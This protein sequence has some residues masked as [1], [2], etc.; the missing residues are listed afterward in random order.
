MLDSSPLPL[1]L[2]LAAKPVA[3][4]SYQLPLDDHCYILAANGVFRLDRNEYYEIVTKLT[5]LPNLGT[6]EPKRRLTVLKIPSHFVRDAEAFFTAVYDRQ[7]SE[8]VLLLYC[9]PKYGWHMEAPKQEAQGLHVDYDRTD[10]P[11]TFP[12]YRYFHPQTNREL[13]SSTRP[14][15]GWAIAEAFQYRLFGTI[16]SHAQAGA[17][18][19]G[20]DDADEKHFDGLHITIGNVDAAYSYSAR[21]SLGG[22]FSKVDMKDVVMAAPMVATRPDWMGKITKRTYTQHNTFPHSHN[23]YFARDQRYRQFDD[24]RVTAPRDPLWDWWEDEALEKK[25]QK[26]VWPRAGGGA[27]GSGTF[28]RQTPS[29][30][31]P[32]VKTGSTPLPGQYPGAG[33]GRSSGGT[34]LAIAP[35]VPGTEL[36]P[37]R[38]KQEQRLRMLIMFEEFQDL[39]LQ[40]QWFEK[41]S[42]E[43]QDELVNDLA[44]HHPITA[45]HFRKGVADT[46]QN[47][48]RSGSDASLKNNAAQQT[49]ISSSLVNT[50]SKSLVTNQ[51]DEYYGD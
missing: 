37:P 28:P 8:A 10:M 43:T 22:I 14:P 12:G 16:H 31:D 1:P 48:S 32:N 23:T 27:Y 44:V 51:A 26:E 40:V 4:Q 24:N 25:E 20:T 18:H 33:G 50:N 15:E 38:N 46:C 17:F 2:H 11:T 9:H 19:S 3:G 49:L 21:W 29:I 6:I 42:K 35:A 41:L 7:Q 5:E 36:L 39:K 45:T 47:G 34:A 13:H 30:S